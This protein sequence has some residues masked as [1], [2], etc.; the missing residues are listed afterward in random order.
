[1]AAR[2]QIACLRAIR[3]L[4]T[5]ICA[6]VA[7]LQ[8]KPAVLVSINLCQEA[9]SNCELPLIH[10]PT[11]K[12][13]AAHPCKRSCISDSQRVPAYTAGKIWRQGFD[14][15]F[16]VPNGS[17]G[18]S[19]T[20]RRYLRTEVV[21]EVAVERLEG[22]LKGVVAVSLQRPHA[23]NALGRT[24]LEQLEE[25]IESIQRDDQVRAVILHSNVPKV[26][27]AGA[28][29]KERKE[30]TQDGVQKFVRQLGA[31][32]KALEDLRVPTIA[33]VEGHALGGG[34]ELALSCDL[35]VGGQNTRLGLPETGLAIIPGAGGTQR[36]PRLV[37]VSKAKELIFT[38][39]IVDAQEAYRIGVLNHLVGPGEAFDKA[40]ELAAEI[41][42]KGPVAIQAA[43][44]AIDRGI[45]AKLVDGLQIEQECYA[46]TL[47]TRDRLEGLA[48][49]A[50]KRAPVYTGN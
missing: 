24:L 23:K 11:R 14:T 48:A 7:P 20:W 47:S 19:L 9:T 16:L 1:M 5:P 4:G 40:L 31:V 13:E 36:L 46:E 30:M 15:A 10:A 38:G 2:L 17:D 50:E 33:A 26:F 6:S 42:K 25:A 37:G 28:D 21:K 18:A 39:R 12:E 27:C 22:D 34:L 29:L 41:L 44:A 49:F 45:E 8:E 35:R 43:K 3:R 32:F